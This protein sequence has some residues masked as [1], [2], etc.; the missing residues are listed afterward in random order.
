M[1]RK[2]DQQERIILALLE[3]SGGEAPPGALEEL[4]E[5]P[6][7]GRAYTELL[8]LIP[9]ELAPVIPSPRVKERLMASVSG[10][11]SRDARSQEEDPEPAGAEILPMSSAV[12]GD[13][14]GRTAG[15]RAPTA[16]NDSRFRSFL[17]AAVIAFL[18]IGVCGW[19]YVQLQ[20]QRE[21]VARLQEDLEATHVR[22]EELDDVRRDLV[23][24][25]RDVGMMPADP[26]QWCPLRPAGEEPAQPD[27]HGS[28][29][30]VKEHGSWSVRIHHLEPAA[31]DGVYVLWFLDEE[32]PLK[33]IRLGR[34][35]RPV[36]ISA[37]GL[38][39]GMT[40]AAV[41]LEASMDTPEPSGPR[42]LYGHSRDMDRL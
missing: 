36:Q 40:A 42:I 27:A 4:Q 35:D 16:A 12:P 15:S 6:A 25:L 32:A 14:P 9:C 1:D 33:K 39:A 11:R 5:D 7:E 13:D 17:A 31:A 28:L 8:G 23:A 41:T 2:M 19:F 20:R 10:E 3:A 22:L 37:T 26:V 24:S 18:M 29:L 38:P 30:L 34:G 21:T